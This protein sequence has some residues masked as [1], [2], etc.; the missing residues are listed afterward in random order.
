MSLEEQIKEI[1]DELQRTPHNK[2]TNQH[3][4]RLKAKLS[5]M[6]DEAEFRRSGGGGGRG[7]QVKK[8]GNATIGLVGFPSVGKSTLLNNITDAESAVAAYHFTTLEVVPGILEYKG[9]KIQVLDMPGLI[10]GASRGRG[11]GREVLAVA[12]SLDLVLL[13]IDVFETNLQVLVDEVMAAGIRPNQKPPEIFLA[14]KDRGGIVV[15]STVKL[16]KLA[17]EEIVDTLNEYGIV[18]ADVVL[19]EDASLDQL[20]D[21]L[22]GN[23]IYMPAL[24]VLNKTDLVNAE[25]LRR[26]EKRLGGWKIIPISAEK[27]KGLEPL[28]SAIYNSLKFMSIYMKPPGKEA[29]MKEP[30]VV[31]EGST[32][33]MICDTIHRDIRPRFRFANVWGKSAKFPG[34]NVGLGHVLK[35]QDV[36]TII[37][38]KG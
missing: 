21:H 35:D 37:A 10:A 38:R 19:R 33:G 34:Q 23:R 8:S 30:M 32:V 1:E 12:R 20:I 13:M 26:L 25:Y 31:K 9:A 11:R 3:I 15:N 17:E 27:R 28:K 16:T 4:G 2:A 18:S 5:R 7:Y 6:R 29:D 24:V 36:L 14:K 22:S